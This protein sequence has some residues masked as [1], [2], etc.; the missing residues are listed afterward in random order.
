M[1]PI[2]GDFASITPHKR[3]LRDFY[4]SIAKYFL[5]LLNKQSIDIQTSTKI[6]LLIEAATKKSLQEFLQHLLKSQGKISKLSFGVAALDTYLDIFSTSDTDIDINKYFLNLYNELPFNYALSINIDL[7]LFLKNIFKK[8]NLSENNFIYKLEFA[9]RNTLQKIDYNKSIYLLK[10]TE[11]L[12]L[13]VS[14]GK[15]EFFYSSSI[16]FSEIKKIVKLFINK[17]QKIEKKCNFSF[18]NYS[19]QNDYGYD[20]KIF[21]LKK[22]T[23]A[24]NHNYNNDFIA[25]NK[26][27]QQF[28]KN[29]NDSGLVILNGKTGTGKTSYIKYLINKVNKKFIFL[30]QGMFEVLSD[31]NFFLFL[32]EHKNTILILE[33]CDELLLNSSKRNPLSSFLNLSEGLFSEIYKY[34]IICSL[35]AASKQINRNIIKKSRL[36][37]KYEFNELDTIKAQK[38]IN[39]LGKKEIINKPMLLSEIYNIKDNRLKTFGERKLGFNNI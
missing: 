3:A 18:V 23:L 31:A 11:K 38:L 29:D 1:I 34:K 2:K 15:S 26:K 22:F 13:L 25:S 19:K 36:I 12:L 9:K 8:Y 10:I 32:S 6:E 24:L 5:A 30:P 14:A 7:A 37:I 35:N 28:L 20:L 39:Q 21:S 33:D 16:D 27:I 4:S 17:E